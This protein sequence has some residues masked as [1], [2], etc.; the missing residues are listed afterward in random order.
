V[1]EILVAPE[2]AQLKVLFEPEVMLV[3]FALN[4]LI[5]GLG[6]LAAFTVTVAV[7]VAAPEEF[8]AV[9]VKVV[10][11]VGLMLIEPFADVEL[12]VPGV[13]VIP[14][15]PEVVH[16][17]ELLVPES[18]LAGFAAKDET[19]GMEPFPAVIL[20]AAPQFSNPEQR[21][22]VRASALR[23]SHEK[24][25]LLNFALTWIFVLSFAARR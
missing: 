20:D 19:I 8:T 9:K 7:A 22:S 13:M 23:L 18:T 14:V 21:N 2:V 10:V 5:V 12:N 16:A 6:L 24:L 3:G 1:I 15:A 11:A 25:R 4:E 17:N